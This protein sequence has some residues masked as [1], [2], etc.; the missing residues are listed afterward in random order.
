[1]SSAVHGEHHHRAKLTDVEVQ[2]IRNMLAAGDRQV[3]IAWIF[4]ISQ[5]QI[6][7]IK[8]GRSRAASAS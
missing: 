5:A 2:A 4:E 7:A 6:S 1:L 8:R 3:D